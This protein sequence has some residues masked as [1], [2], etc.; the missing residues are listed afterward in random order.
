MSIAENRGPRRRTQAERSSATQERVL[1]AAIQL[2]HAQGY[3]GATTLAISETAGVSLGALQHQY[4]TKAKL[5][6]AVV[7]RY[8]DYR[9]VAYSEALGG[10]EAPRERLRR[11]IEASSELT[12]L[13]EHTALIEIHLARRSDPDL[14]REA[15]PVFREQ[16]DQ[17]AAWLLHLGRDAGVHDEA[18]LRRLQLLG[19]A[20]LRGLTIERV[21]GDR[22]ELIADS[23]SMWG[24]MLIREFFRDVDDGSPGHASAN[25]VAEDS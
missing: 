21:E 12:K 8:A 25:G 22:E 7:E 2:L 11:L 5:M 4:P 9:R 16:V 13:P 24:D 19:N 3:S 20:V 23:L 15:G 18:R 17:V 14:D 6:A 10:S 1:S